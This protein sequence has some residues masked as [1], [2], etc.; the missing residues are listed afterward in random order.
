[1]K[2]TGAARTVKWMRTMV[3]GT[4]SVASSMAKR[5]RACSIST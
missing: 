2:V 5:L 4:N 1:M 3:T